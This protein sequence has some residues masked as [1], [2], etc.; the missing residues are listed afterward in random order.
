MLNLAENPYIRGLF[1]FFK[2]YKKQITLKALLFNIFYLY[3][4]CN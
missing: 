2:F 4:L 1:Y 3:L